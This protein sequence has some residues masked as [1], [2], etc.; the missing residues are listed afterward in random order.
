MRKWFGRRRWDGQTPKTTSALH[1]EN[2]RYHEAQ[3]QND[4]DSDHEAVNKIFFSPQ[5]IPHSQAVPSCHNH[6]SKR[7]LRTSPSAPAPAPAST[8]PAS[9]LRVLQAIIVTLV[10]LCIDPQ[11]VLHLALCILLFMPSYP[12]WIQRATVLALL[13]VRQ[14]VFARLQGA[15]FLVLSGLVD[16]LFVQPYIQQNRQ[17]HV[18]HEQMPEFVNANTRPAEGAY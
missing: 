7:R 11:R 5:A 8:S 13:V 4:N 1:N 10:V 17:F 2:G 9:A 15:L 12:P 18:R 14:T 3:C 16:H 6:K